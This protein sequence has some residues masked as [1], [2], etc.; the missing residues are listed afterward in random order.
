MSFSKVEIHGDKANPDRVYYNATIVNNN[1]D[2]QGLQADP[3]ITFADNRQTPL[4]QDSSQYDVAVENFSLN[5][6]TKTLPLFIPIVVPAVITE[7]LRIVGP[8][9]VGVPPPGQNYTPVTY[10]FET[11]T[12]ALIPGERVTVAG[13]SPGTGEFN[14]VDQKVVASTPGS[15]TVNLILGT[16]YIIP[17]NPGTASFKNPTDVTTTIYSV[18]LN[19]FDGVNYASSEVFVQWEPENEASYNIIPT[20]AIPFQQQTDYYY[21]YSYTYWT[22]LMNKALQTAYANIQATLGAFGTKCPFF[23]F[24]ELSGLFTLNQD[25][26]TSIIPIG[27]TLPPPY[28]GFGAVTPTGSYQTGEYSFVGMNINLEGLI[29]NFDTYYLAAGQR[30]KANPANPILP[31]VIFD[32]GLTNLNTTAATDGGHSVGGSIK[33]KP[34][35]SSFQLTNPFTGDNSAGPVFVRLTQDYVSTGTLWSPI[36]SFVIA[37]TQVP[38]RS[39]ANANPIP[40]GDQNIGIQNSAAGAFQRVLIETPINATTAD[41]WRGWVLYQP[42]IPTYSSLDPVREALTNIDFQLFW[43]NRLTNELVPLRLYNEGTMSIRILFRRK[44]T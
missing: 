42:L 35:V 34:T 4:L 10:F 20:T 33:N 44:N 38:V 31:E 12:D 1:S 22:V 13:M 32:F 23:E 17:F 43:R 24:D 9:S 16:G 19:V 15:F 7:G 28:D 29:S 36:A 37:T 39:E 27:G 41:I 14:F 40:L 3:R 21:C 11:Y 6:A 2:T 8:V 5:G 25:A 18:T 30:W 26:Q